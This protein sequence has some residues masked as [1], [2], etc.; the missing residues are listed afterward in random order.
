MYLEGMLSSRKSVTLLFS[1]ITLHQKKN[2]YE[3]KDED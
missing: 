1:A 3:I 2:Q